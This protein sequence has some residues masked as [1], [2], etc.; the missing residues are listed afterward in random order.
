[1]KSDHE[2]QQDVIDQLKF[3]PG[4]SAS[5]IVVAVEDGVVTLSG[6]VDSYAKKFRAENVAKNVAGVKVVAENIKVVI[7]PA[8]SRTDTEIAQAILHALKWN[9]AVKEEKMKIEVEDGIVTLEGEVDWDF[10]R[11][12]AEGIIENLTG[13]RN[14]INLVRLKPGAVPPDV[15]AKINAAFL[16]SATIDANNIFAEV[17]GNKVILR[18]RV[19]SHAESADAETAAYNAPGVLYVE[20]KL[21]VEVPEYPPFN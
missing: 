4:L 7:S 3:D 6:N 13:V 21:E 12:E 20:N 1:M 17:M 18:G 10:E 19:R 11:K 8:H 9:T 16:R 2:I 15:S 14:V 5:P